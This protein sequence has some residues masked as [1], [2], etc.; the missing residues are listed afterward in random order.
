MPYC[1]R[2]HQ[3]HNSLL[4]H[5]YNRGNFRLRIFN[6]DQDY[7][8]FI[9]LIIEYSLEFNIKI[10]HWVIMPNHYHLLL[11]LENPAV[12]SN[13]MAGLARTY[14]CY[15]HR[16]YQTAGFLWQGRFKL[17]PIQKE[18]YL[19]ACGRYIERNPVD[20]GI[21]SAAEDYPYSSAKYYC[22]GKYE[23][24]AT[25]SPCFAEFGSDIAIKRQAYGRFLKDFNPQE[26][27]M[28]TNMEAPQGS[29]E[30]IRRLFVENGRYL[31][32]R[33]GRPRQRIVS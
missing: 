1:A 10:Y 33:R 17:Q 9:K 22:S 28:F 23:G 4:Y 21:V 2:R 11:E 25:E 31:P 3:L 24:I 14:T 12:I 15:Y 29:T 5:V 18:Q 30:F 26:E 13:C 19:I 32:R 16:V 7:R 27:R 8:H 6:C 20:A